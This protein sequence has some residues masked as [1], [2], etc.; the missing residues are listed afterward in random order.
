M[1]GCRLVPESGSSSSSHPGPRCRRCSLLTPTVRADP[2]VVRKRPMSLPQPWSAT[3]LPPIE[4]G[5]ATVH[6][7]TRAGDHTLYAL[8]RL[9]N[10]R[11]AG[12]FAREV[13]VMAALHAA[14]ARVPVLIASGVDQRG[15]AFFVMPW[16]PQGSLDALLRLET[17]A[18][19]TTSLH[20]V[21]QVAAELEGM[22]SEGF[23]H[24]TS[25]SLRTSS[26]TTLAAC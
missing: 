15:R 1:S 23:A 21:D 5:Q 19:P 12:R 13:A 11:R 20:L 25:S 22:H 24:R 9:K 16:Y 2:L 17:T 7:V 6:Q 10:P 4:S 3:S 8:K 18:A 14:G 26:S